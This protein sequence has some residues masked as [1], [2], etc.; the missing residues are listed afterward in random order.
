MANFDKKWSELS[1]DE[2]RRMKEK[3]VSRSAWRDAKAK[4][5]GYKD[6]S[7]KQNQKTQSQGASTGQNS[8]QSQQAFNPKPQQSSTSYNTT[9]NNNVNASAVGAMSS[10]ASA[11]DKKQ[12]AIKAADTYLANH[13]MRGKG[14][15][16]DA[17]YDRIL[18]EGG[19]NNH[20]YQQIKNEQ[21]KQQYEANK[22]ARIESNYARQDANYEVNQAGG[23]AL[24]KYGSARNAFVS[25]KESGD[26]YMTNSTND[27]YENYGDNTNNVANETLADKLVQSGKEFSWADYNMHKNGGKQNSNYNYDAYGGYDNWYNNH[28]AYS[29]GGWKGSQNVMDSGAIASGSKTRND[30]RNQYRLSDEYMNKYGQYDWAQRF[31]NSNINQ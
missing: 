26:F 30:A 22:A 27:D 25:N 9:A 1:Q 29:E 8:A 10:R 2:Q 15:I 20:T 16:K 21:A 11:E 12:Q 24:A 17:E 19:L 13:P 23:E 3:Y 7:D 6:L 5:Q 28:S 4:S 18:K 14:S 31:Y